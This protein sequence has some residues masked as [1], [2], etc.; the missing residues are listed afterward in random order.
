[1]NKGSFQ[2]GTSFILLPQQ[3]WSDCSFIGTRPVGKMLSD[4]LSVEIS[5]P[6][7]RPAFKKTICIIVIS[8]KPCVQVPLKLS[9]MATAKCEMF[10]FNSR[11]R[12]PQRHDYE[13]HSKAAEWQPTNRSDRHWIYPNWQR[14]K[15]TR[16][17]DWAWLF[18]CSN[19]GLGNLIWFFLQNWKSL[20]FWIGHGRFHGFW[21]HVQ[22]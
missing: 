21:A 9:V 16:V 14:S 5:S 11:W 20:G 10:Y 22:W 15:S 12:Y 17:S 7:R 3:T 6:T 18:P 19:Q 13:G 1:M 2:D 4:S 8:A